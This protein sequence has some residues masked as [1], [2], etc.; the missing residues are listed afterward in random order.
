MG[1]EGFSGNSTYNFSNGEPLSAR[2]L[3]EV[4]SSADF[5]RF[6][7]N[8]IAYTQG[9]FG[10]AIQIDTN[11]IE[12]QNIVQQFQCFVKQYTGGDAET[13]EYIINV[14]KGSVIWA[15]STKPP[16]GKN[17]TTDQDLITDFYDDGSGQ[18]GDGT[19]VEG[20]D[21]N[22]ISGAGV[23]F[24]PDDGS[25]Y[26]IYLFKATGVPDDIGPIIV[27]LKD[28]TIT[29]PIVLPFDYPEAVGGEVWQ[30][31]EVAT[32]VFHQG[33]PA[34]DPPTQDYFT[35]NQE[36]IGSLTIP[37][38][39]GMGHP[40]KVSVRSDDGESF[41]YTV[42]T[43]AVNNTIPDNMDI[44]VSGAGES[45]DIYLEIT[46]SETVFPSGVT[47][48]SGSIPES[49]DTTSYVLIA[50]V[51]G[52]TVDQILTGSLWGEMFQCGTDPVKYWYSRV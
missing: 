5:S 6:T 45:I 30:A 12:Q 42:Q 4:A 49:D 7:Q 18:S 3:N 2:A 44:E 20:D 43:G 52:Y 19:I 10:T 14:V 31:M 16:S 11:A 13:G 8:N 48:S 25:K 29:Y 26:G 27:M 32:F 40:F 21:N 23:S 38:S 50:T 41:V 37:G 17:D 28:Y 15:P 36:L 47:I 51:E 9:A 35:I 24:I 22:F 1:I 34:G 33:N 46:G 39:S